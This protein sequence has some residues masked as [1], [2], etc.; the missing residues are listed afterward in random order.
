MLNCNAGRWEAV[1]TGYETHMD[2]DREGI[3]VGITGDGVDP[4]QISIH[5]LHKFL[6]AVNRVIAGAVPEDDPSAAA[7]KLDI[8][9]VSVRAGSAMYGIASQNRPASLLRGIERTVATVN[10]GRYIGASP[11]M[12]RGLVELTDFL[13]RK[14]VD[15]V[16]QI[17]SQR[18]AILRRTTVIIP[19][20]SLVGRT[21][22]YGEVVNAGGTKNPT[23]RLRLSTGRSLYCTLDVP[24]DR[25]RQLARDIAKRLYSVIGVE[26]TGYWT[27]REMEL[28]KFEIRRL[29]PFEDV[30]A[31]RAI[32]ELRALVGDRYASVSGRDFIRELRGEEDE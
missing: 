20:G 14:R 30:S 16:F 29:L 32:S 31:D 18:R 21:T 19:E 25:R 17:G 10:N 5:D 1:A 28:F 12:L 9:L 26:G 2:T 4:T 3:S 15:A 23:A 11:E 8:S 6:V 22:L 27:P 7:D 24:R 13:K